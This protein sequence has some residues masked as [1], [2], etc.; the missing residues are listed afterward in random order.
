MMPSVNDILVIA[1]IPV[2]D[3]VVYPH[4]KKSLG[5]TVKPLHKVCRDA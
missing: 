4:L 5:I 2:L 1:I 3:Y